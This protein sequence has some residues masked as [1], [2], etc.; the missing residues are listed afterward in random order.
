MNN[1]SK[2]RICPVEHAG[3]LDINIRRLFQNP[4]KILKPYINNGMTVLDVGC[5]PGF[6]T[7]EIAKLVGNTGKVIGADLQ[8]GMLEKLKVKIINLKLENIIK[9]HKC[10]ND[11]IG[12]NEKVDFILIF[13]MYH[14]VPNKIDFLKEIHSILKPNGKVLIV[15]PIFHVSNNDFNKLIN[16]LIE[17]RFDIIEKPKVFFSRALLLKTV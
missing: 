1:K 17:N 4:I 2:N 14:E 6:F 16:T 8:E 5:G 15:E 13:Y 11:K 12:L 10:Q 3:A 9:L 7:T